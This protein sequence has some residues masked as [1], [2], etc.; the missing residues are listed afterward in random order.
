M[1]PTPGTPI[2]PVGPVG[3]GGP[4]GMAMARQTAVEVRAQ[5]VTIAFWQRGTSWPASGAHNA[6]ANG[7]QTI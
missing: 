6:V 1:P 5:V 7:A 4:G 2:G 3:P